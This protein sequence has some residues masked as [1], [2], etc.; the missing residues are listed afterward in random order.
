MSETTGPPNGTLDGVP[1]PQHCAPR[2]TEMVDLDRS[3]CL[4][5]L[6]A[7]DVGRIAVTVTGWNQPMLRPVNY[8][9]DDSSQSVLIRSGSG[10]KLH[11]VLQSARAAFEIDG[12]DPAGRVGWSVIVLGV[13]EEITNPT[14]LQR[15]E[16]LGLD[17]WAPGHKDRW[18]R[19][20][21]NTVSG[22]RIQ[23]GLVA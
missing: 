7:T 22:R 10:S 13:A 6:A 17:P 19:I 23:A 15:I 8:V 11:A 18:I 2:A 4:R 9:F 21:A 20:R 12:T 16:R 14:E 1:E 3:E 5:L